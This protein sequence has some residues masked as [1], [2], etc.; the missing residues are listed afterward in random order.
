MLGDLKFI[1]NYG[2]NALREERMLRLM[3]YEA[4]QT[5]ADKNTLQLMKPNICRG[6]AEEIEDDLFSD[7]ANFLQ[8]GLCL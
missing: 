2:L 8:N 4:I 5:D 1:D 7:L 3:I 6:L